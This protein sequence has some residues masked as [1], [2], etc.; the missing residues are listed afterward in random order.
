[1]PRG[2]YDRRAPPLEE[3]FWRHVTKGDGCWEWDGWRSAAGYGRLY[4]RGTSKAAHR[5]S[6]ELANGR[7]IPKGSVVLH[8]C[9]NP[10]CVRPD[11]LSVGS[12]SDNAKDAIGKGRP[13]SGGYR[14]DACRR[15]HP[16]KPETTYVTPKGWRSCRT[17]R[18]Y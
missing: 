9:D 14:R 8:A 18:G 11:H 15:G 17:C 5:L 3:A 10:P 16:W 1:M 2:V 4:Y 13:W 7:P 6:W 12:H